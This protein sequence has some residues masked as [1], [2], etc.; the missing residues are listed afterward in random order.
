L[1]GPGLRSLFEAQV[2]RQRVGLGMKRQAADE[3]HHHVVVANAKRAAGG[4]AGHGVGGVGAGVDTER[5]HRQLRPCEAG[6]A[7][8][9]GE[10]ALL[11][12]QHPLDRV[13]HDA[14]RADQRVPFLDR[15]R[16]Q[17][18]DP[19]HRP[20]RCRGVGD[21]GDRVLALAAAAPPPCRRGQARVG[22]V[23][24]P[25][26]ARRAGVGLIQ[27]V[28]RPLVAEA[29]GQALEV[30]GE[31]ARRR[32]AVQAVELA[33]ADQAL[34]EAFTGGVA[35]H[36]LVAAGVEAFGPVEDGGVAGGGGAVVVAGVQGLVL[37]R[38]WQQRRQAR[39]AGYCAGIVGRGV[40]NF[41][42]FLGLP[43]APEHG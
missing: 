16:Q 28:H 13:A 34:E 15:R 30:A 39:R 23:Q 18:G 22:Q 26:C 19:V 33:V 27:P 1:P 2:H 29:G 36:Q 21:A 6:G 20:G 31:I 37:G 38:R 32:I 43:H 25:G 35:A 24:R 9:A 17:P 40:G 7:E 8:P 4:V 3:Q 41:G 14:G 5:N 10:I 42:V 12:D 11:L